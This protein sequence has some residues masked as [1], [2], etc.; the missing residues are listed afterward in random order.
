[1]P[2]RRPRRTRTAPSGSRRPAVL[3]ALAVAWAG[4]GALPPEEQ[5]LTD[6]FHAARLRD[7][8]MAARVSSVDLDPATDG[9]VDRFEVVAIEPR[10]GGRRVVTV[11]ALVRRPGG[12]AEPRTMIVTLQRAGARGWRVVEWTFGSA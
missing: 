7:T 2:A 8:T 1:M 3:L 11:D 4:C 5:V 9:I 6:F 12:A 10:G